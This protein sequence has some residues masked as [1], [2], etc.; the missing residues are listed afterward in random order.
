MESE[1]VYTVGSH[2]KRPLHETSDRQNVPAFKTS[3]HETSNIQ[4][5]PSQNVPSQNVP[6]HELIPHEMST[7]TKCPQSPN[8]LSILH[9]FVNGPKA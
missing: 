2:T 3:L 7:V 9:F 5:V 4:N 8:F 6:C 1:L